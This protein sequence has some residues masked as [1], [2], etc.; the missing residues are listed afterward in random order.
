MLTLTQAPNS[1]TPSVLGRPILW[2]VHNDAL[3]VETA[4]KS[5]YAFR[6]ASTGSAGETFRLRGQNFTT[7]NDDRFDSTGFKHN[8][9]VG[10]SA[11][12]LL[13]M[14]RT[15]PSF[16]N[17]SVRLERPADGQTDWY[18]FVTA[19]DVSVDP[20]AAADNDVSGLT[21][22][23]LLYAPGREEVRTGQRLWWRLYR[24]SEALT[25]EKYAAFD[26]N[27]DASIDVESVMDGLLSVG[28]P[29]D[30]DDN[31]VVWMDDALAK[32]SLRYGVY[33]PGANGEGAQY[34][35]TYES[36]PVPVLAAVLQG[37]Q[38]DG[39]KPYGPNRANRNDF[40]IDGAK[41]PWLT[42]R[43]DVRHVGKGSN[44]WTAIYLGEHPYYGGASRRRLLREFWGEDTQF[45]I[46]EE[47][48][49]VLRAG[50][51]MVPTGW[52]AVIAPIRDIVKYVKIWV[53]MDIGINAW[54]RESTLLTVHFDQKPCKA[55]ELY[56]L[57]GLGS[58]VTI[59]LDKVLTQTVARESQAVT[60]SPVL[61]FDQASPNGMEFTQG[62]AKSHV[63][64]MTETITVST[65]LLVARK[66]RPI[67]SAV[68]TA[69]GYLRFMDPVLQEMRMLR[70]LIQNTEVP[71]Y[72]DGQAANITFTLRPSYSMFTQ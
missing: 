44:H 24:G 35:E 8:T 33:L 26:N 61:N 9:S 27:A 25:P 1:F 11:I 19:S 5:S 12:N 65:G 32:V 64:N 36:D 37:W 30:P 15:N 29:E 58:W 52:N 57:E 10:M 39:L 70:V 3:I 63:T 20:P 49:D 40:S 41:L 14:L 34:G 16:R 7:L 21:G 69:E 67:L 17:Y 38:K 18:V 54:V 6:I 51:L 53:E 56:L 4:R 48:I 46:A 55:G 71:V 2:V 45:P 22:I 59:P 43:P 68:A 66:V 28:F 62:W 42:V 47:E 13:G 60:T 31:D 50:M 23:T 72:S